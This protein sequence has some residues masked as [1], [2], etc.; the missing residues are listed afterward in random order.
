MLR[1]L[2]GFRQGNATG[3]HARCAEPAEAGRAIIVPMTI[4][5]EHVQ[6]AVSA[7]AAQ[8]D[9]NEHVV[10]FRQDS[11]PYIRVHDGILHWIV[12][13]R[14]KEL[15]HR[16][17]GDLNELLHWVALDATRSM[18]VNWEIGQ[19]DRFPAGRDTR[20]GWLAKQ[21]ELLRR[22]DT[23]WAE[24]FRAGIPA[25]CPGVRLEDVDAHPLSNPA[26]PGAIRHTTGLAETDG[27]TTG[28][29]EWTPRLK[30]SGHLPAGATGLVC[31]G[32]LPNV[33]RG[34]HASP[35]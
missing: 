21:L 4:T 14:G 15:Q 27:R 5:F 24:Q 30:E 11:Y 8:L 33:V 23:D 7:M 12:E 10:F 16:T 35:F 6:V 20:I 34:Q 1:C 26:P 29:A 18:A 32:A 19:R 22:L 3:L 28:F 2:A 13:E 31:P 17:T 9:G 25:L